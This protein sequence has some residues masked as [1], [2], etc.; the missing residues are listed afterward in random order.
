MSTPPQKFVMLR[1]WKGRGDVITQKSPAPQS[2]TL[3]KHRALY[4]Q[5]CPLNKLVTS[6]YFLSTI[7]TEGLIPKWSDL[8]EDPGAYGRIIWKLVLKKQSERV[9]T[10]L[11]YLRKGPSE[12][13]LWH[14]GFYRGCGGDSN[15][16]RNYQFLKKESYRW[17]YLDFWHSLIGIILQ[18]CPSSNL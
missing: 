5:L 12:K 17:S 2:S 18:Y 4:K 6:G 10:G 7:T 16:L 3:W 13:P 9:W 8:L 11:V 1:K 14:S 15:Q